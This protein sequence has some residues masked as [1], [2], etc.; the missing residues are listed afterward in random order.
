MKYF[1]F[2]KENISKLVV[3]IWVRISE[4]MGLIM[5]CYDEKQKVFTCST[6]K[7]IWSIIIGLISAILYPLV[8]RE[9]KKL[10]NNNF[11]GFFLVVFMSMSAGVL[12]Y[13]YLMLAF[14]EQF[15]YRNKIRDSLN[16]FSL[17]VKQSKKMFYEMNLRID[18]EFVKC[19]RL[20]LF[21]VLIKFGIIV[22]NFVRYTM[23][24]NV[25]LKI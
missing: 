24:L 22:I 23:L 19:R 9:I 20:F 13:I 18:K 3:K 11:K 6:Y 10:N 21:S 14:K 2:N 25:D 16:D 7:S 17:F 15:K 1:K 8:I 12:L 5:V 4:L